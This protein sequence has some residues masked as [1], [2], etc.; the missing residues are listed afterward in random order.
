MRQHHQVVG[1][2]FIVFSKKKSRFPASFVETLRPTPEKAA[3]IYVAVGAA[4]AFWL[5]LQLFLLLATAAADPW[6][7]VVP[8][9]QRRLL[10]VR[11]RP[12]WV[13]GLL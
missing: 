9:G 12:F 13:L 4:V 11:N 5:L 10:L 8:V 3:R 1:L 6:T 7:V 2:C